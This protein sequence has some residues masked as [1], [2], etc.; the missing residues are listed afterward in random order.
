MEEMTTQLNKDI[1]NI[2]QSKL[3]MDMLA[4]IFIETGGRAENPK[5]AEICAKIAMDFYEGIREEQIQV[6][7]PL[8]VNKTYRTKMQ[9]GEKFTITEI[10]TSKPSEKI[11]KIK[12]IYESSPQIGSCPLDPERLI[13]ETETA[14]KEIPFCKYCSQDLPQK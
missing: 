4:A 8:E 1:K 7:K 10:I 6:D 13:P 9:T 14:I 3:E 12:G 11:I 5:I 2:N